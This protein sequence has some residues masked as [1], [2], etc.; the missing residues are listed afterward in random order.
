[1]RF[2]REPP[3]QR[4]TLPCRSEEEGFSADLYLV[5]HYFR[6]YGIYE[7]SWLVKGILRGL[8]NRMASWMLQVENGREEVVG[9]ADFFLNN[10]TFWC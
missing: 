2:L 1:M 4:Q 10:E 5:F 6:I 3:E 9:C 8:R 7:S